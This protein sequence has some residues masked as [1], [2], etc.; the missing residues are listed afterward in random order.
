MHRNGRC[1][2]MAP[3]RSQA[4]SNGRR[5]WDQE[6]VRMKRLVK[7]GQREAMQHGSTAAHWGSPKGTSGRH[8]P[9]PLIRHALEKAGVAC[10]SWQVWRVGSRDIWVAEDTDAARLVDQTVVVESWRRSGKLGAVRRGWTKVVTRMS[11]TISTS[12]CA[13]L[14]CMGCWGTHID[15]VYTPS[16]AHMRW[17]YDRR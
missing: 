15:S 9:M 12:K 5:K 7:H 3:R 11:W 14:C 16:R 4:P 1:G 17:G 6:V 8:G 10:E 13:A 2:G